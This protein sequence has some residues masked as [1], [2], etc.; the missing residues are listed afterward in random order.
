MNLRILPASTR[1]YFASSGTVNHE[2]L[3]MDA[4]TYF[5][6][7][8]HFISPPL[9]V[10]HSIQRTIHRPK[11]SHNG[12]DLLAPSVRILVEL[13]FHSVIGVVPEEIE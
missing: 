11:E 3:G 8:Q 9:Q 13:R 4:P 5:G 7:L 2:L 10:G 6:K 1:R 12:F